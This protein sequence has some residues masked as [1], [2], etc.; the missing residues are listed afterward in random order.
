MKPIQLVIPM[1]GQGT[2]FRK[3]GYELPKPLIPVTE[4]PIIERLLA[5]FPQNW[6]TTFIIAENHWETELPDRLKQLRPGC[7]IFTVK[8]HKLGPTWSVEQALTQLEEGPI[9][10]SYCDYAMVWDSAQ[11][12]RF[13][14]D[15][16]CEACV[17][18]YR[19]FHAH[20]LSSMP[21][22]YLR[23]SGER[24]VE[25]REKGWFTDD[26]EKEYA[27]S[28][29][30]YFKSKE[31]LQRAIDSQKDL[32]LFINGEYYTSLTV[33]GLLKKD[34]D[35]HVRVFEIPGFFQWGTPEDLET[36]CYWERCFRARN[37]FIAQNLKVDQIL[38]PMAGKGSRF[39][40]ISKK[41]KPLINVEGAPMFEKA[42]QS[43]PQADRTTIIA[44]SE[45]K[46]DLKH[47]PYQFLFLDKTPQGQALTT[48]MGLNTLKEGDLIISSCDHALVLD[49]A[50]WSRFKSL[51]KYDAAI[52]TANGFPN[53]TKK[54]EDF[55]W[56]QAINSGEFP[57]VE[58]VSVKKR[59][60]NPKEDHLL[61]GSFWF[62]NVEI[63]KEG[64]EKLKKSNLKVNGELY[65]DSIFNFLIAAGRNVCIIPLDG[66]INWG[67]PNSLAESL[68]W[69]E[70]L[71]ARS[72]HRRDRFPGVN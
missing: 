9:F 56:V 7:K 21:Y 30:Y 26:R 43:L 29:G 24:V 25:I 16:E 70:I 22:A 13:V 52:F 62:R 35:A 6:P 31:T 19:G 18:A 50:R 39:H 36:Y 46:S 1:S 23:L 59:L 65:L 12:E 58:N 4:T 32:E 34:P 10:I 17:I 64:I 38:M 28:G 42:L 61:V 27:S 37:R 47:F 33:E 63:V 2:R 3:A 49:P 51:G 41:R 55:S 8:A 69:Y 66:Y 53:A 15:S 57:S 54:P 14:S 11:F 60:S 20:Y 68:Y 45:L 67:D 44:L 5:N 40:G 72:L 48:D 71:F